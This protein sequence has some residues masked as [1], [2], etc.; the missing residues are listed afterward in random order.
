MRLYI[1]SLA[2]AGMRLMRQ[3]IE[4][5][6]VA[7]SKLMKKGQARSQGETEGTA[8]VR[9]VCLLSA[10]TASAKIVYNFLNLPGLN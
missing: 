8:P 2:I 6:S 10:P 4:N 5:A 3:P 9:C 1:I 7:E